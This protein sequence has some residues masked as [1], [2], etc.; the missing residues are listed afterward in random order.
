VHTV[1]IYLFILFLEK[2]ANT[3]KQKEETKRKREKRQLYSK[4]GL[5]WCDWDESNMW[6]LAGN[7]WNN[8]D[9]S[10]TWS[11]WPNTVRYLLAYC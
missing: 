8:I 4:V 2:S 5:A 7:G 3:T 1:C 9:W 10:Y 6:A 11:V